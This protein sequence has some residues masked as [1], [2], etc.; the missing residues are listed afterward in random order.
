MALYEIIIGNASGDT[1][2][3]KLVLSEETLTE[4]NLQSVVK[5]DKDW[6]EYIVSVKIAYVF[7]NAWDEEEYDR[8]IKIRK[9]LL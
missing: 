3:S 5:I 6:G 1:N 8:L 2:Y 7:V 4:T 9:L